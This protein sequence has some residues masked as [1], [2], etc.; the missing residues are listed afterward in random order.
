MRTSIELMNKVLAS[1]QPPEPQPEPG[2]P[3]PP[4]AP[5]QTVVAY[6]TV[7]RGYDKTM[8]SSEAEIDAYLA[9]LREKLTTVVAGGK[10]IAITND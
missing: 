5:T 8:I 9:F 1:V 7:V 3:T 2:N 10:R 4:P 6:A